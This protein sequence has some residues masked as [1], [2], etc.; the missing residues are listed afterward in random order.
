VKDD[1]F[2][3]RHVSEYKMYATVQTLINDW[4]NDRVVD[5]ERMALYEDSL[6]KWLVTERI[7]SADETMSDESPGTTRVLMNVMMKKLNEKYSTVL[8]PIQKSV[9]RSYALSNVNDDKNTI[10]NKL[11]EVKI[12][13][14]SSIDEFI[15]SNKINENLNDKLLEA[16]VKLLK[17]DISVV[18]DGVV[19]RFMLYAK[20]IHELQQNDEEEQ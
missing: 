18:D 5:F 12:E 1:S 11:N 13:L 3:D 14:L 6:M 7:A 10:S 19:T 20:L 9:I 17:E 16:K 8:L 15:K 4:K 2:F